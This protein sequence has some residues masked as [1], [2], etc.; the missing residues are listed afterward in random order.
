MD[1]DKLR[2]QIAR[3]ILSINDFEEALGYLYAKPAED[4]VA[5]RRALLSAAIVAYAR[6]FT[7]NEADRSTKATST[8]ALKVKR[9]LSVEQ[10]QLHNQLLD[11]RSRAIAH[12]EHALR[13]VHYAPLKHPIYVAGHQVF[14]VLAQ[15][16][17]RPLFAANCEALRR[18]AYEVMTALDAQVRQSENAA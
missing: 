11:Y 12:A 18:A 3:L 4:A 6:P 2:A 8:V 17:D 14:D 7:Q 1:N 15:P 16:I 13:P 5:I 10:L 9:V